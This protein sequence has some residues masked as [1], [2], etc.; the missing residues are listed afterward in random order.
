GDKLVVLDGQHRIRAFE[1]LKKQLELQNDVEN[2]EKIN[3]FPLT[4]QDFYDLTVEQ[5]RQLFTDIN[6]N[7]SPVNNYLLIM[8]KDNDLYGRLVKEIVFN[9]PSIP[10]D[11]FEIRL[12]ST[13]SK[14]L[15]ASTLYLT[16]LALNDGGYSMNARKTINPQNYKSYK[17]K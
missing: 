1:I 13:R 16:A 5:E 17:K 6:S 12:K 15:T 4:I 14:L 11:L 8:Y 9:H 2:L 3:S 10:E 7:S